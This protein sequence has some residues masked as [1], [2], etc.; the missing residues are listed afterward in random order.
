MPLDNPTD[1]GSKSDLLGVPYVIGANSIYAHLNT[2]YKH[3]HNSAYCY[4]ERAASVTLTKAGG[5]WADYPASKTEIIPANTITSDFDLHWAMI[6]DISA[7][8]E[9]T[10]RLYK[11]AAGAEVFICA[12]AFFRNT[13]MSQEGNLPVQVPQIPA[14]TRISGAISSSNNAADTCGIKLYYHTY[15]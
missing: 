11:G 13:V 14:N 8:G 6:R 1:V 7:N 2:S 12:I 5:V 3:V 4:P 15:A 10:L 9:Y